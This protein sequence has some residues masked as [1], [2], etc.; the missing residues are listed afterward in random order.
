MVA[1]C[2]AT[3]LA[4]LALV[5]FQMRAGRDPALGPAHASA[6]APAA[7]RVLVRRIVHRRLVVVRVEEEG[8]DDRGAT[9]ARAGGR[10][11][12]VVTAPAGASPAPAAAPASAPAAPA[13]TTRS[14]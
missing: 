3:F 9:P 4:L 1:L 8:D 13:A 10:S 11:T 2:C 7:R 5:S 6:T 12:A 14:S